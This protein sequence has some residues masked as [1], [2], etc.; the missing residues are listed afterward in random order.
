[1]TLHDMVSAP[2]QWCQNKPQQQ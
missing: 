1:M 2:H